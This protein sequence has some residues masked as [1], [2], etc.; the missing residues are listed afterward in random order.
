MTDRP[1]V[2]M[3]LLLA[4][5]PLVACGGD[6]VQDQSYAGSARRTYELG[7]EALEDEDYEE[8]VRHFSVV[9]NK[10]AYSRYAAMAELR[11]ADTYFAQDKHLEA[12]DAYR[13]FM[14]A[15][16]SHEEVSYAMWRIGE[17]YYR[18]IP[19]DFFLFPPAHEKDQ[20]QTQDAVRHLE[21]FVERYP[22]DK[23]ADQARERIRECR[24][25]LADYELYVA[26][27]YLHQ[28]RPASARGRLEQ[29]V[30]KFPDLADRW[31]EAALLLVGAY[32]D[33]GM[34]A[35]ARVLGERLVKT[36]PG[37]PEADDVRDVLSRGR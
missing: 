28:E 10:F 9:K 22:Q 26:K 30:E 23:N 34:D 24:E 11:I 5:L 18:Q 1:L 2:F 14:Q 35:E 21:R 32:R 20:A 7:E 4:C 27:F 19:S 3:L 16:P 8:A 6:Q 25:M 33:L 29:V 12:I 15:H 13:T 17:A 37:R 31:S 36:H